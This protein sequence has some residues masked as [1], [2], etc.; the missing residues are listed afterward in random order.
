MSK[1]RDVMDNLQLASQKD[2]ETCKEHV[3]EWS[4]GRPAKLEN[5]A[6]IFSDKVASV[7]TVAEHTLNSNETFHQKYLEVQE[8]NSARDSYKVV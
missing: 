3:E 1:I 7:V 8:V 5:I 2:W 6:H 4:H